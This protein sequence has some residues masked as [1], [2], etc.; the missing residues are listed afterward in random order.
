MSFWSGAS[1]EKSPFLSKKIEVV[2]SMAKLP[3]LFQGS[4]LHKVC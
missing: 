2:A 4:F 1:L 3:R